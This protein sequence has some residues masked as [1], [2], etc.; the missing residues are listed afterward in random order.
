MRHISNLLLV[1]LV[2][3]AY[4]AGG[5][6]NGEPN[7]TETAVHDFVAET[8]KNMVFVKGGSFMMG[9]YLH[10][11]FPGDSGPAYWPPHRD[12]KYFHKV[13]L[14]IFLI[15]KYE[16]TFQEYDIYTHA[17]HKPTLA[18][19]ALKVKMPRQIPAGHNSHC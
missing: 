16:V 14:D 15:G 10:E 11:P 4:T 17:T 6:E 8:L 18:P 13:T 2:I 12:N 1:R 7:E 3:T 19:R 5:T 9:D